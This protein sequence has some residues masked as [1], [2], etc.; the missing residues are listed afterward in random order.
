MSI[1]VLKAKYLTKMSYFHYNVQLL[2]S[3]KFKAECIGV[4]EV[5]YRERAGADLS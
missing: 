1:I 2:H 5:S 3:L 4:K